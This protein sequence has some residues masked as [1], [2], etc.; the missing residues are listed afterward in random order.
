MAP[1]EQ[2][3]LGMKIQ[4]GGELGLHMDKAAG[5]F[6]LL[7]NI[8]DVLLFISP[9]LEEIELWKHLIFFQKKHFTI[10]FTPRLGHS[11]C[12]GSHSHFLTSSTCRP[13]L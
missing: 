8:T 4:A 13:I 5:K 1:Q 2:E 9:K 6:F 7:W 3:S 12:S 11:S 10:S